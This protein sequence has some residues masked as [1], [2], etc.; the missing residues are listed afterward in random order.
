VHSYYTDTVERKY[1]RSSP[2]FLPPVNGGGSG[3]HIEMPSSDDLR[4]P[5]PF[6]E[7]LR[8]DEALPR[9]DLGGGGGAKAAVGTEEYSPPAPRSP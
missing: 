6:S 5:P 3:A 7:L 9:C 4:A 1:G 8:L 2:A